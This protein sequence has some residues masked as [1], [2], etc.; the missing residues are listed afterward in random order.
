MLFFSRKK[1]RDLKGPVQNREGVDQMFCRFMKGTVM[2]RIGK[3]KRVGP[4]LNGGI[5][6]IGME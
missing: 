1:E 2:C 3:V 6:N 5:K 4:V